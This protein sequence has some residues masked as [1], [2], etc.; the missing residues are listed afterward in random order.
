MRASLLS[1]LVLSLAPLGPLHAPP[2]AAQAAGTLPDAYAGLSPAQA[3]ELRST[4]RRLTRQR[5]VREATLSSIAASLRVSLG[6][7]SFARLIELVEIRAV[8]AETLRAELVRLHAGFDAVPGRAGRAAPADLLERARA[9]FDAG[10]LAEADAVLAELAPIRADT[11]RISREDW[12]EVVAAR[13][14]VMVID[15]RVA[16][17]VRYRR[18][19]SQA[20]AEQMRQTRFTLMLDAAL[21]A[22]E[23]GRRQ[24]GTDLLQLA[25]DTYIEDVLPLAPRDAAPD[26]WALAQMNLGGALSIQGE[27]TSGVAGAALLSRSVDAFE[28][29]LTVFTPEAA[30]GDWARTQINLSATLLQQSDLS[31]GPA[32]RALVGRSIEALRGA[33]TVYSPE[34]TPS[35]W[36]MAQMNL[37][38]AYRRLGALTEGV[39][40]YE[41]LARSLEAYEDALRVYTID[42]AP[43]DWAAV[44]LN[45]GSALG[46]LAGRTDGA[47]GVVLLERSVEA[48]E[49]ALTVFTREDTPTDWGRTQLML[50]LTFVD[51]SERTSGLASTRLIE[52][53]VEAYRNSR[54]VLLDDH[55]MAATLDEL[56]AE[57]EAQLAA[58]R[59]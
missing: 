59:R 20:L 9:A 25:I 15:G 58:S 57:R 5:D 49:R 6:D 32:A 14:R 44:Q 8:E 31:D 52:R 13:A 46:F 54:S 40:G 17:S 35:D 56:I 2:V 10:R 28:A 4:I 18:Q 21:D 48:L 19:A 30:S 41:M 11:L 33:L 34:F 36:A 29:A 38:L 16:E 43:F 55:P 24:P 45:I 50:G 12:E 1:A 3:R 53:A 47:A 26:S 39:A 22:S 42:D 27:R 7:T 51:M 23:E 37:G